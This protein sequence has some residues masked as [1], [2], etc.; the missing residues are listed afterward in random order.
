MFTALG[1]S[2]KHQLEGTSGMTPP[3]TEYK[4][5]S[6]PQE[7]GAFSREMGPPGDQDAALCADLNKA[8]WNYSSLE[9]NL[10]AI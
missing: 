5:G 1:E 2:I 4:T 7:R 10:D 3:I 9:G 6:L 8:S